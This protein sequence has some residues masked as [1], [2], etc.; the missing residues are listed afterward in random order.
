MCSH[1]VRLTDA[2]EVDGEVLAW[3]RAAYDIAG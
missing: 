3:L 2:S 1:K